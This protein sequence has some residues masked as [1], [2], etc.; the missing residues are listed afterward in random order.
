VRIPPFLRGH[1]DA[2]VAL[3]MYS[4][5]TLGVGNV[6]IIVCTTLHF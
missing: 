2:F 3:N 4:H 1:V 6:G 5:M